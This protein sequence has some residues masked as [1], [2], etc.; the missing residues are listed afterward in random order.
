MDPRTKLAGIG[1]PTLSSLS[2]P[3]ISHFEIITSNPTATTLINTSA[4][5]G[6][7]PM[8]HAM[9]AALALLVF[10]TSTVFLVADLAFGWRLGVVN[11]MLHRLCCTKEGEDRPEVVIR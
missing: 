10:I 2:I 3:A 6:T 8:G 7:N 1:C 11:A 4:F 9:T 5:L